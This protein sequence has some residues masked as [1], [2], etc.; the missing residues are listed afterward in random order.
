MIEVV[1]SLWQCV[2][3]LAMPA[4]PE[5][6][7]IGLSFLKFAPDMLHGMLVDRMGPQ[8]GG[9]DSALASGMAASHVPHR[10]L[11]QCWQALS[12]RWGRGTARPP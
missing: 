7:M 5:W 9:D 8:R 1:S 6:Q 12:L 11:E 2:Y 4:G 3:S 10:Q